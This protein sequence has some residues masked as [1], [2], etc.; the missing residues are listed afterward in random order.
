MEFIKQ[1]DAVKKSERLQ[2]RTTLDG[3]KGRSRWLNG[4]KFQVTGYDVVT[5]DNGADG[6]Y[7]V[8]TTVVNGNAFDNLFVSMILRTQ[9]TFDGQEIE[10]KGSFNELARKL[11]EDAT[12]LTDEQFCQRLVAECNGKTLTMKRD[13][14]I[15]KMARDG[16]AYPTQ[17]V[18]INID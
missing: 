9:T 18:E 3:Y 5:R 10:P 12:I 2:K 11:A 7:L 17:L 6:D 1:T 4:R 8:L 16:S 13:I 15:K 14:P